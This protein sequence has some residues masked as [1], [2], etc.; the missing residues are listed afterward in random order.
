MPL[1]H[2]LGDYAV[3][4][5]F[6]SNLLVYNSADDLYP[7]YL[8]HRLISSTYSLSFCIPSTSCDNSGLQYSV[9]LPKLWDKALVFMYIVI[10]FT[11]S[12]SSAVIAFLLLGKPRQ[13]VSRKSLTIIL[14]ECIRYARCTLVPALNIF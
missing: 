14:I 12:S 9:F 5:D 2:F 1:Q 10:K 8:Y 7:T 13:R 3:V 11:L 6:R 4:R